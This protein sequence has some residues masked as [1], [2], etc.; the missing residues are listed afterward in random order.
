MM[1]SARGFQVDAVQ[2]NLPN[3]TDLRCLWFQL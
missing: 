3:L 2:Q 1:V